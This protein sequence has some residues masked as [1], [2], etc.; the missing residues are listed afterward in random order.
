MGRRH[1]NKKT[2]ES[3]NTIEKDLLE[4]YLTYYR[5]AAYK[6][7]LLSQSSS[8]LNDD[9]VINDD[10][11]DDGI[12]I[13]ISNQ[14]ASLFRN[15]PTFIAGIE[16]PVLTNQLLK[17]P[18][19]LLP[20][21][22]ESKHRRD[23][24]DLCIHV[25]LYQSS[26]GEKFNGRQKVISI[27]PDGF[28]YLEEGLKH[29]PPLSFPIMSCKPWYFRNDVGLENVSDE[30]ISSLSS[31]DL[32]RK[33]VRKHTNYHREV[34]KELSNYPYKCLRGENIDN[35][36]EFL[37][38]DEN[39]IMHSYQNTSTSTLLSIV[40][41]SEKMKQCAEELLSN[42]NLKELSFDLEAYNSS[43]Y[44]QATCLIQLCT[45]E[46]KEYVI[47]V[48]AP[49]VWDN[50]SLL[51]P[52]FANPC[53][54]KVG[55]GIASIDIPCLHRDFGIFVVN[56]FDTMEAAKTLGLKGHFGLAK[57]C[58]YYHLQSDDA[59]DNYD[60]LKM[61]YQ[62]TDWRLRP[63]KNEMIEYGILDVR[64]LIPLRKLL[65]RDMLR[66]KNGVRKRLEF[67]DACSSESDYC[68]NNGVSSNLIEG[69]ISESSTDNIELFL[70]ASMLEEKDDD[71][72][73]NDGD[74][75]YFTANSESET[76]MERSNS[77]DQNLQQSSI[78]K[79]RYNYIFMETLRKSQNQCMSF[80]T[81]KN[82]MLE[83]N[84]TLAKLM[85]RAEK[86]REVDTGNKQKRRS[87]NRSDMLLYKELFEWRN[88]AAKKLGIIPS[89]MCSLDILVL[90]AYTRP[91]NVVELKR[92]NYFLTDFF[93]VDS[94]SDH[95]EDMFSIVIVTGKHA[96]QESD[97]DVIFYSDCKY[98]G[99]NHNRNSSKRSTT[100]FTFSPYK[101]MRISA[102][103]AGIAAFWIGFMKVRKR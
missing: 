85:K 82:E 56:G 55:H 83:K 64:F 42:P 57:L 14:Q 103:L 23:I 80:W 58:R 39:I 29:D 69:S 77:N 68:L 71:E 1:R 52:I 4:S 7:A 6:I 3:F 78:N 32:S 59:S 46:R 11:D 26:V 73:D 10:Y 92:V 20:H 47:D 95:L 99:R 30:P 66:G 2:S 81:D 89:M 21:T 101:A 43:K 36:E 65:I 19:L 24:C 97:F 51:C 17:Q 27:F 79:L 98:E 84:D 48:L 16:F 25:G 70:S 62:S 34:I 76:E 5:H 18:Y 94:N 40:D 61:I 50:V 54:V 100:I 41:T 86:I 9:I 15:S 96:E 88:E 53:I 8:S 31:H 72:D 93:L 45:N 37:A 63:L 12:A 87:W 22:L 13:G 60:D 28:D 102:I 38:A 75:G 49:G 74:S 67:M 35:V 44:K 33:F 90:I 91:T